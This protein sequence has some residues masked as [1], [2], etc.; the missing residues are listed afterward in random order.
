MVFDLIEPLR[1]AGA[2]AVKKRA[3]QWLVVLPG[4]IGYE[5]RELKITAGDDVAF[6]HSLNHVNGTTKQGQKIDMWW[7]ATVC[8][9]KVDGKW[10][11]AHEHSSVPFDMQ[12]GKASLGL[13]P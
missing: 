11:V 1:Y 7:R 4:P 13:N 9:R 5:V 8:F 12:S 6:C 3:E 10:V 2:A